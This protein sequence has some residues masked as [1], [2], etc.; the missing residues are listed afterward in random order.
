MLIRYVGPY[1]DDVCYAQQHH[2]RAGIV[3]IKNIY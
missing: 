1:T 3:R 2:E